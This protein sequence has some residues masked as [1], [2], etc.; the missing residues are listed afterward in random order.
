MSFEIYGPDPT[1]LDISGRKPH[2]LIIGAGV[3]GLALAIM[4][5]KA[6]IPFDI[7]EKSPEAR[8]VGK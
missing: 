5:Q 6:D 4:L 2:V 7:F 3:A 1:V 8:A